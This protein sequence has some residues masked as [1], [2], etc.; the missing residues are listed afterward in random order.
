VLRSKAA[1]SRY[2]KHSDKFGYHSIVGKLYQEMQEILRR[3]E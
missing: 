3:S 2:R 1:Y